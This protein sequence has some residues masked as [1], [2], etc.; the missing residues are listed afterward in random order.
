MQGDG[1][2]L[3]EFPFPNV[4]GVFRPDVC[5]SCESFYRPDAPLRFAAIIHFLLP[6]RLYRLPMY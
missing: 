3:L 5:L 2:V 6:R 1:N 4:P